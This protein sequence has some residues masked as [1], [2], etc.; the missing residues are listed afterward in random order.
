MA[1]LHDTRQRGHSEHARRSLL[2]MGCLTTHL[3]TALVV[4]P[5]LSPTRLTDHTVHTRLLAHASR[6]ELT[7]HTRQRTSIPTHL[8]IHIAEQERTVQATPCAGSRIRPC[9]RSSH[10]ARATRLRELMRTTIPLASRLAP[11]PRTLK[12][13][14]SSDVH[15]T[16]AP[17]LTPPRACAVRVVT[18]EWPR[19]LPRPLVA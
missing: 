17:P 15:P 12:Q 3:C 16:H 8:S 9:A 11:T 1:G 13:A 5:S 6:N 2:L 18:T 4:E 19:H 7:P 14:T 10:F